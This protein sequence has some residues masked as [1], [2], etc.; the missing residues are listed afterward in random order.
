MNIEIEITAAVFKCQT[1]ED[2]FYQ[3]LSKITGIKK[4]VTKDSKLIVS[5]FSTEKDQALAD[6]R[7]I[8]DIWH[9]S[10]NLM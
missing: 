6:I 5:V 1:D 3:R 4:I 10:I 8:C 9:A 2:I 7:A